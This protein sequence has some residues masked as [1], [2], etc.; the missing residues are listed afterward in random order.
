MLDDAQL[1]GKR[2][3]WIFKSDKISINNIISLTFW[4]NRIILYVVRNHDGWKQTVQENISVNFNQSCILGKCWK[5]YT[6]DMPNLTLFRSP[7][8]SSAK[9][10]FP[11]C[12]QPYFIGP[13]LNVHQQR[14]VTC[15]KHFPLFNNSLQFMIYL[16]KIEKTIITGTLIC[17]FGKKLCPNTK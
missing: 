15:K 9:C 4:S 16:L 10:V 5:L 2:W 13:Y 7:P 12:T 3:R 14:H 1:H 17:R 6:S 11:P 8:G